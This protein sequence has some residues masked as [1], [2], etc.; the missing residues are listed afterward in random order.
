MKERKQ[1]VK[2]IRD[3][4]KKRPQRIVIDEVFPGESLRVLSAEMKS[5]AKEADII[6]LAA[7]SGEEEHV[8]SRKELSKLLSE[9]QLKEIKE[10]QV[11][12]I[13][14]KRS[15]NITEDVRKFVKGRTK[16]LLDWEGQKG[17]T[18]PEVKKRRR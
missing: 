5:R 18:Q 12:C 1:I 6:D 16:K 11:F 2:E 8:M 17:K 14:R 15:K 7:W 13:K 9:K 4:S 3:R 10:G